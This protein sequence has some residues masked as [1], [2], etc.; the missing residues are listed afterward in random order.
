MAVSSITTTNRI[1]PPK[2]RSSIALACCLGLLFACSASACSVYSED[3][4]NPMHPVAQT[5]CEAGLV[6]RGR[7]IDGVDFEESM[8]MANNIN[9]TVRV[10]EAINAGAAGESNVPKN[11]PFAAVISGFLPCCLCGTEAP[12]VSEDEY[13]FFVSADFQNTNDDEALS[14]NPAVFSL[15]STWLGSG[16]IPATDESFGTILMGI[17]AAHS[18]MS[19]DTLYCMENPTCVSEYMDKDCPAVLGDA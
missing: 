16:K 4:C 3:G 15:S 9:V 1:S 14:G 7:V 19:C 10:T 12:A 6:L 5:A 17:D 13:F 18:G 11:Y 2:S 8:R